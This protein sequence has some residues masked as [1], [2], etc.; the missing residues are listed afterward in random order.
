MYRIFY[1]WLRIFF[2]LI[3]HWE[4]QHNWSTFFFFFVPKLSWQWPKKKKTE[5]KGNMWHI[6]TFFGE[7]KKIE[8][9]LY[10]KKVKSK[11]TVLHVSCV[12]MMRRP[13]SWHM[14]QLLLSWLLFR[15]TPTLHLHSQLST[16]NYLSLSL[17]FLQ[18]MGSCYFFRGNSCRD[19]I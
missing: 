12:M 14:T 8:K 5:K 17:F 19:C 18:F 13:I 11:C 3:L 1:W 16:I 7:K 4:G 15:M 10:I 2:K 9:V 6:H